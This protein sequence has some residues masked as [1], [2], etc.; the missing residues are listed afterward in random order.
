MT[1]NEKLIWAAVYAVEFSAALREYGLHGKRYSL[2]TCIENA[3]AAVVEARGALL[4]TE[5]AFGADSEELAMLD[6][7]VGSS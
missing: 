2:G 7:M 4:A 5:V 3:C 1:E 6:D